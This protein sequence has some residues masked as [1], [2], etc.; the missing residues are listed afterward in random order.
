[1]TK[2]IEV[3]SPYK[4]K[5]VK[6][7]RNYP[8]YLYRLEIVDD[9]EYGGDGNLEMVNCYSADNGQ[10]IGNAKNA[11][12]LCNKY[13][14]RD[15]Q[16]RKNEHSV[17]SI[18]FNKNEQKYYGWSHRAIY[19]FGIGSTCKKGDCGYQPT[20]KKDFMEDC[21]CFWTEDSHLD[22]TGKESTDEDGLLGVQVEWKYDNKIPNE[23]LR[24][25]IN[26]AF[27]RYP[28]YW[29]KGEWVAKTLE[30]AKQMA[31]DFAEGV[32]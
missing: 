8:G 7:Q 27:T 16:K 19:G 22:I 32:S 9:S 1:M 14:L 2:E 15:I 13:G 10:W 26:G 31:C 17:C 23:K 6:F 24:S 25:T 12:M 28:E 5:E 21:I 30:D 18:G 11:R 29:G 3:K 20:D 4:V